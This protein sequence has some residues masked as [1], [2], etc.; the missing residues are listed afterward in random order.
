MFRYNDVA[1]EHIFV[2]IRH[3][4]YVLIMELGYILC[5][6]TI[7]LISILEKNPASYFVILYSFFY[8][9]YC[10]WFVLWH[11]GLDFNVGYTYL[12]VYES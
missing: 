4:K 11:E 3:R 6:V 9:F 2:F 10:E 8:E 12:L 5:G 7:L 1:M